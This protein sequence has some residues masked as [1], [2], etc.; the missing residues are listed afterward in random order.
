M[1]HESYSQ[2]CSIQGVNIF[3]Y[4]TRHDC[5]T[6]PCAAACLDQIVSAL[7]YL[8]QSNIAH[9]DIKVCLYYCIVFHANQLYRLA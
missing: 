8:H 1:H 6:E 7:C 4:F 9:L 3:E 2:K 5:L